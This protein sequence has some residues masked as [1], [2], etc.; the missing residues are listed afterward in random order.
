MASM[1]PRLKKW[2]DGLL[3]SAPLGSQA[4]HPMQRSVAAKGLANMPTVMTVW[5]SIVAYS[6]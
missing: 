5:Y 3:P 2:R 6:L 4:N 1:I